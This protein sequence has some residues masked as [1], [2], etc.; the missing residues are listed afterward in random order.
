MNRRDLLKGLVANS[1]ALTVAGPRHLAAQLTGASDWRVFEVTTS[2]EVLEPSG[3]TLIWV[4]KPLSLRTPF[5]RIIATSIDCSGGSAKTHNTG[6]QGLGVIAVEF[7]SGA[8]PALK[9][10]FRVATRDRHVDLVAPGKPQHVSQDELKT[11]LQPTKYIPIDG[12]VRE[13]PS[14]HQGCNNGH[15]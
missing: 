14:N 4:P 7:P 1:V 10:R 9:Y 6:D 11:F 15:R 3:R 5:Q 12:I 2:V 13:I 8:R